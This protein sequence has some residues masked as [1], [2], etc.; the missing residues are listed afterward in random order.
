M[1]ASKSLKYNLIGVFPRP[2]VAKLMQRAMKRG[3]I[4]EVDETPASS[5][6][7]YCKL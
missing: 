7:N 5:R 4:G 6:E 3:V 2:T 1:G